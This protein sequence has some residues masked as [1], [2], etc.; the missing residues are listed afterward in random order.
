MRPLTP[1]P[2]SQ[3]PASLKAWLYFQNDTYRN[4]LEPNNPKEQNIITIQV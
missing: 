3:A 1:R 2:I 4:E